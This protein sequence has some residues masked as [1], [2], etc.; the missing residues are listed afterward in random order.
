M[1]VLDHHGVIEHGHVGHAA[2]AMTRV[3]VG[4]ENRI[5]LRCRH[6]DFHVADEV[7]VT[8]DDAPQA[9]GRRE[10]T[11]DNAHRHASAAAFTGRPIGDRLA[12]AKAALGQDIVE[13]G[14][15]LADQMGKHLPLF[16]AS[17]IGAG[18]RR[19]QIELRRV[20]GM[21][22]Q[23]FSSLWL[24]SSVA[25]EL[26]RRACPIP[27]G[28]RPFSCHL[29]PPTLDRLPENGGRAK[30]KIGMPPR[31]SRSPMPCRRLFGATQRPTSSAQG[32][33]A[34]TNH[35]ANRIDR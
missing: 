35:L 2:V 24:A 8:G 6:R 34:S 16:L 25:F 31:R 13:L 10:F 33:W 20:A 22:G 30:A 23:G 18:G 4:A 29:S 26:K 1:T 27:R 15:A 3:E 11:S 9:A 28:D 12:A 21:L 14:G 32:K 7:A 19:S 5:L 17:Q